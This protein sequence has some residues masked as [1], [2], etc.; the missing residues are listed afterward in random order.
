MTRQRAAFARGG[1]A[2]NAREREVV[3]DRV[4]DAIDW[5][6]A[7]VPGR[8]RREVADDLVEYL[9]LHYEARP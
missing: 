1:P 3:A 9:K 4:K 2:R 5:E 7:R 8:R 6:L